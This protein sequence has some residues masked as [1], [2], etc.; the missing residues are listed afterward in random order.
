MPLLHG[1][2]R[3]LRQYGTNLAECVD[4]P[5]MLN[6]A[7]KLFERKIRYWEFRPTPSD[8]GAVVSPADAKVI[9]GSLAGNS[10]LFIKNKFFDLEELL[11]IW[12][13]RW[14]NA[15]VDGDFAIFRL[16]PEKYHYNH[17][18][19]AGKVVD[20]Y[21]ITGAY[22]SCNP[23]AVISL[24]AP[25]SKNKRMVT[26]IDSDVPGGTRVGLVAM[27]EVVAL[28]IGDVEQRYSEVRYEDPRSLKVGM[29]LHKG[30]P[31]SLFRPGSSTVVLLFEKGRVHFADD[32]IRNVNRA[33]V[34]SRFSAGFGR[35]LVETELNVR[36]LIAKR[37]DDLGSPVGDR[38]PVPSCPSLR[39]PLLCVAENEGEL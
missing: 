31:K 26:I 30:C 36:S 8:L 21:A 38:S 32:L 2:A 15:F 28:M 16:T 1:K 29:F 3:L 27:I 11:S 39:N 19:V 10:S 24:A 37:S 12:S 33:D 7:R 18:P 25:Y 17:T 35:P 13:N 14:T 20:F 6:T 4:P 22:N 34:R 23:A 5:R 9:I